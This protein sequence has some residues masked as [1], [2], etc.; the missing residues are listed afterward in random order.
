MR[1]QLFLRRGI[2]CMGRKPEN[3]AKC[4]TRLLVL[5]SSV[6]IFASCGGSSPSTDSLVLP[7]TAETKPKPWDLGSESKHVHD[8]A[9]Y[10]VW[11]TCIVRND[12]AAG[13][14]E[15]T[16]I[17][18]GGGR[19]EKRTTLNVG[20]G[21]VTSH[22]FEFREPEYSNPSHFTSRCRSTATQQ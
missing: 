1:G 5:A 11:L 10:V 20:Q 13:T 4:L 3:F 17:L 18:E 15:L 16:A 22:A 21:Q 7:T 2:G 8:D 14:I 6:A 19:W 12:G 9:G